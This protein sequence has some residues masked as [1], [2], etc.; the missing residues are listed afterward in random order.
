M[1]PSQVAIMVAIFAC[2]DA[3]VLYA[4][5]SMCASAWN[6][7]ASTYPIN[8]YA[9]GPWREFQS[10]AIDMMN[11]GFCVHVYADDQYVHLAPTKFLRLMRAKPLSI[12]R[13]EMRDIKPGRFGSAKVK[14]G[15]KT[16]VL[17]KWSVVQS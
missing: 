11:F 14:L 15:T 9:I 10:M 17:P 1:S 7:L 4:V 13:A 5:A 3:V 8:E 16:L 2:V 6:D 12:P